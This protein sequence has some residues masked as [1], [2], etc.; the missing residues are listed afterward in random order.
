MTG[1]RLR[2]PGFVLLLLLLA[3]DVVF[4]ERRI[5]VYRPRHRPATELLPV[6]QVALADEGVVALDSGSNALVLAGPPAAVE[7]TLELLGLQDRARPVVV[8]HWT[9][10]SADE[11]EA[12]GVRIDWRIEAGDL[13]VGTPHFPGEEGVRVGVLS[14]QEAGTGS[15]AGTLRLLDGEEGSLGSGEVV[16]LAVPR[17]YGADL[18]AVSAESGFRARPRVLDNGRVQVEITPEQASL[19]PGGRVAFTGAATTVTVKP[20]ET[21]ALGEVGGDEA[22]RV[23]GVPEAAAAGRSRS[24]RVLLLRVE[25]ERP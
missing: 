4:A 6:A 3:A 19:E 8:L 10:R 18:A 13:R 25:V 20:G 11:I 9:S 15:F 1:P 5:E 2:R 23:R 7:R 24:E 12:A 22:T 21:L 17:R 16:P 14:R